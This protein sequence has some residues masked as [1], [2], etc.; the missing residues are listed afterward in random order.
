MSDCRNNFTIINYVLE[1]A[2]NQG[3]TDPLCDVTKGSEDGENYVALV[4]K[5]SIKDNDNKAN[6]IDIIVKSPNEESGLVQSN[7]MFSNEIWA[8]DKLLST[9]KAIVKNHKMLMQLPNCI[10]WSP[11]NGQEWL[12]LEDMTPKG[13]SITRPL[14]STL[15]ENH[16]KA[17]L[18]AL[19]EFHGLSYVLQHTDNKLFKE[20]ADQAKESIFS[21]EFVVEEMKSILDKAAQLTLEIVLIKEYHEKIKEL[22]TDMYKKI[23]DLLKSTEHSVICHGDYWRNNILFKS[24]ASLLFLPK[25]LLNTWVLANILI[26]FVC[27]AG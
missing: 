9:F 14:T 1:H 25:Y 22:S 27:F 21:Q 4:S 16:T 19:A 10:G 8:Y 20:L 17:A 6:Q 12:A 11:K 5:L 15:D 7:K 23:G 24:L 2:K 18:T 13:F 3:F 26:S